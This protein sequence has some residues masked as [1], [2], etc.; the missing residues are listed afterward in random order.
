MAV[1]PPGGEASK[2]PA[3]TCCSENGLG[4]K[5]LLKDE[6]FDVIVTDDK[7]GQNS[8]RVKNCIK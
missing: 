6:D 4:L 2:N 7:E 1:F 3:Y 8:G 5:D